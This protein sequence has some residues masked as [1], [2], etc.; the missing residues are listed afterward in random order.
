MGPART[1]I[2]LVIPS[3]RGG[4]AERFSSYLLR[5]LDRARFEPH[6]ALLHTE[7]AYMKDLAE[8]VVVHK[9]GVSRVRY[10][11]PGIVRVVRQIKPKI[12]FSNLAHMNFCVLLAKRLFPPGTMV[13]A[14]E[15]TLPTEIAKARHFHLYW[16]WMQRRIYHQA[17]VV[18]SPSDAVRDD[19]AQHYQLPREKAIR[20]Y[21]PVDTLRVQRSAATG[22]NP[23]SSNGHRNDGP[24]LV[25][26]GRLS[27]AKG[28]D[29]LLPA[30]RLVR[31]TY[32]G[33]RLAILGQGGL[34]G[35]LESQS[36]ALGLDG[37]VRFW[38]FQQNPWA[39]MKHADLFV[40]SS[41][42]EGLPNVLLEAMVLHK[43]IV[44]TDCPG[45]V[46]EMRAYYPEMTLVPPE[47]PEALAEAIISACKTAGQNAIGQSV[48]SDDLMSAFSLQNV[49]DQYS[50]LFLD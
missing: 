33:I 4:G 29:V 37:A 22:D 5:H 39:F 25:A 30:M 41:R 44:A 12:V 10:A 1:K 50:K 15:S 19:V 3:L 27:R 46:A 28:F 14:R 11:L 42:Y 8:D 24:Q 32:P 45:G 6:V 43:P 7:G 20:I 9:I 40:L 34:R 48:V 13:L 35:D 47:N 38:G 36:R 16:R 26:V 49:I 2:L 21:N 23:Y 31:E 17:D 18:I